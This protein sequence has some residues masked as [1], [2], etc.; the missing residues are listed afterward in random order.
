MVAADIVIF[1]LGL[2]WLGASVPAIGFSSTLLEKGLYPFIVAD[3]L[4]IVLASLLVPAVWLLVD[5]RRS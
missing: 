5:R 3:L 4:K 2:L 1:A